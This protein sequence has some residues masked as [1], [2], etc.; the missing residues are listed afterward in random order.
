MSSGDAKNEKQTDSAEIAKKIEVQVTRLANL[1]MWQTIIFFI[2]SLI[3]TLLGA[4]YIFGISFQGQVMVQI[5][6]Y[7]LFVGLFSA[8]VFIAMPARQ[9][10]RMK[11]PWYDL[12]IA[13]AVLGICIFFAMKAND[14]QMAG[15]KNIP[16]AI[17]IWMV[18]MEA[19]RR[20]GGLS[21]LIVVLVIGLY[22]LIADKLP[23]ILYGIP[24]D[25]NSIMDTGVFRDEGMMGITT[26]IVAEIILGFLVFAGVLLASGAGEFFISLA[27]ALLGGVRG[28]PAKVSV[29]ASAFFGSL[30]GSVFSNIV[31]T[32]AITIPTMKRVGYPPHYAGAIEACASTGG[33]IMPPVM[34]AIAFVMAVT[35]S[36]D[37]SII[38]IAAVIPSVLYYFGLLMQVDAYAAKVGMKGLP[39]EELPTVRGVLAK[40][41]PFLT[42]MIF[43]VWGLLY[44]RWEYKAPWYAALLMVVLS[45]W[46][47]ETW[48]TP[49]RL[50][51]TFRQ[52]GELITQTAAVI[53]PIAFVVSALTI[54]G[55]TG[56]LTS[57]LVK[58]GGGNIWMV[59]LLGIIACYV[60]GMA[61]LSIVAYIFLSVTLAPAI[62]KLGNLNILAVHLF[63]VYYA[64][65]AGI[66]P[67]VAAGA[68]LGGTIAGAPPMKTA[69]TAMRLGIVIYF[70][71]L[72]F[73]FQPAMVLQGN[74]Y[75]LIYILPT[76]IAGIA[77][78]AAGAEGYLILVGPVQKWA[79]IPLVIA[80]FLLSFP[81]V[82]WTLIGLA[83]SAV[84]VLFVWMGNRKR[85]LAA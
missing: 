58:L 24:Y 47:R 29:I 41:W 78:I 81:T 34:G 69:M 42:V 55:I 74:L 60:M 64:M 75:P 38:M 85:P 66:T 68:F 4:S 77:L 59:L 12:L 56:S 36:V 27:N 57:S 80:G 23:G 1:P 52:I 16:M 35:I 65:L 48:M 63:I 9:K 14:M 2:L 8:C 84:M 18:M 83:A 25:F 44:M 76:C 46:N 61:G 32:G 11:I 82:M 71:P 40:G 33:T 13:A 10:D 45:F 70:V 7:W 37:Y 43:L 50:Y 17:V 67:P 62:I 72:F 21:Y 15:W 26:K 5:Q 54:T 6:Y 79:R 31:G 20:G 53:L 22:P 73:V 30:S 39:K 3:G 28:G 51:A 19:A 49:K